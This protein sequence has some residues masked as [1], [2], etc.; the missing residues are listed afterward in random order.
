MS[1]PRPGLGHGIG[2]RPKHFGRL[3]AERPP[4]DWMEAVSENYLLWLFFSG[5]GWVSL[6]HLLGRVLR[7]KYAGQLERKAAA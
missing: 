5:P 6:D 7:R 4:V 2:L 1:I 3:L